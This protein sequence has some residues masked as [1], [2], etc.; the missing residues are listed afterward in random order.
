MSKKQVDLV[1]D[2]KKVYTS[3]Y[4]LACKLL[5]NRRLVAI[6]IGIPE[7]FNGDILRELNPSGTLLSKYKNGEISD[8]EYTKIYYEE[9]LSKLNA[10]EIYNK[11][12]GKCLICYCG[13]DKFCHRKLVLSWLIDNLGQ[14]INGGEI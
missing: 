13:K 6:S 14:E 3:Y 1:L 5:P 4:A 2:N 8:K 9:T 10:K 7:G 12:A 11:I